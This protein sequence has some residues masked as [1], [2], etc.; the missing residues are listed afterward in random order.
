MQIKMSFQNFVYAA[1]CNEL[2][3][4]GVI[5][6]RF[7]VRRVIYIQKVSWNVQSDLPFL[8]KYGE[9]YFLHRYI[10]YFGNVIY[11]PFI[12]LGKSQRK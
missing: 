9:E 1:Q 10:Q 7:R 8:F 5:H 6:P 11:N 2:R 3:K 12:C 4:S